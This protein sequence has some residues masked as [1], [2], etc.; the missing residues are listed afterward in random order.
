[1]Q[2]LAQGAQ[3]LGLRL[4]DTQ[5][6]QFQSYYRLLTEWNRSI[7]LTR[8]VDREEVQVKHFLDSLSLIRAFTNGDISGLR[9]LDVGS[10]AG[11]PGVPLKIAF[12]SVCLSLLDSI[13]KKTKFLEHLIE[14][15]KLDRVHVV[16]A[17]AETLAHDPVYRETFDLVVGRSVANLR[18]LLELTLPFSKVGGRVVLQK[19]ASYADEPGGPANAL[20]KL[21]GQLERVLEVDLEGLGPDRRLIVVSKTLPTPVEYPRRLGVPLRHPL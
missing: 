19:D 5:I 1:M 8:I 17:R 20:S 7:N 11:F 3:A 13:G 9:V 12:P 2:T 16:T 10:G 15:L 14:T 21:G 18:T 4:N 6:S